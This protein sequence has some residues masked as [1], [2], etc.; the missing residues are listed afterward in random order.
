MTQSAP[1]TP[2][3]LPPTAKGRLELFVKNLGNVVSRELSEEQCAFLER[4]P[5]LAMLD[6]SIGFLK[7][8]QRAEGTLREMTVIEFLQL[9]VRVAGFGNVSADMTVADVI[10]LLS[11]LTSRAKTGT[12]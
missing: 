3:G 6:R 1:H 5:V 11:S 4:S 8:V 9:A 10:K 2:N 12:G 7:A